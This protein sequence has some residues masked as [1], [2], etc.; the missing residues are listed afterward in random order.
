MTP[1]PL[2]EANAELTIISVCHICTLWLE[3][4]LLV[5]QLKS[6]IV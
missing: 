6:H 1:E 2:I 3:N 5:H 4:L